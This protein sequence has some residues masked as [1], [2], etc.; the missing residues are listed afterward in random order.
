MYTA[1]IL[2]TSKSRILAG[3]FYFLVNW[4][5]KK[6]NWFHFLANYFRSRVELVP[7]KVR[8]VLLFWELV[9]LF[10]K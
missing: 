7:E 6:P 1:Q 8:R 3:K 5:Y 9:S 10:P 4:F 2:L